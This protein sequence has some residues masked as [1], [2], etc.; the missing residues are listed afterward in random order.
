[1]QGKICLVTGANS[2]IG[3]AT[4][5]ELAKMGAKVVMVCRDQGRGQTALAEIVAASDNK[6]IDLM[7]ADLSSQSDIRRLAE[8]FLARYDRLH[9]LV[10]NAGAVFLRRQLTVDGLEKT[11]ALNHLGYFLLT[12]L[13]LDVIKRS[14]PARIVNVAS[15]AHWRSSIRFDDLQRERRYRFMEVY[16]QSKLANILFTFELSRRL[17]GSGVTV[18]CMHPGFVGSNLA[19]NNGWIVRLGTTLIKPFAR[20]PKKGAE[21]VVYLATAPELQ[22]CSGRYYVDKKETQSSPES[23]DEG[24]ARRLWQV[25][26]AL[27]GNRITS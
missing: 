3:K 22:A 4:A 10:N 21:T 7:L 9:V 11:F 17:E 25:S 16:G 5:E 6:F 20:S 18:N 13:L 27:T 24:V 12:N 14:A 26:E 23:R 15:V 8:E 2:G 19:N 1:M